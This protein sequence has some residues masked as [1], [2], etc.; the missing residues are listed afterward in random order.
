VTLAGYTNAGKSTLLHR[1]ADDL[2]VTDA[3]PSHP[4]E[5]GVAEI[6]D[7]LFKTLETTTRRATLE[8]RPAL[9]TDTVGFVQDLPHW[10]V[11]SFSETLSEAASADVVVLVTDGADPIDEFEA[12]L[13]V[14][15]SVLE[16]QDVARDDT[17]VAVNKIDRQSTADVSRRRRLA[18]ERVGSVVT[19]S[20]SEGSNCDRLVDA[21]ADRLPSRRETITLPN[22]D[23]AMS[24]VSW[25]YDHVTVES[26]EYAGETVEVTID[27]RPTSIAKARARA[28]AIST[29]GDRESADGSS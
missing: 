11:Q 6:E 8:G 16:E 5:T 1:L 2:S 27:G 21:I 10:L 13:D 15:L 29:G 4:D 7:R 17:V 22:G 23:E 14:S 12:K 18:A 19:I 20:A 3:S 25:L 9:V 26:V 24:L 28:E